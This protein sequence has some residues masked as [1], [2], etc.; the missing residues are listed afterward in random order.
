MSK[1]VSAE[2]EDELSIWVWLPGC[3]TYVKGAGLACIGVQD[4]DAVPCLS[5]I[6]DVSR[7]SQTVN[8]VLN[9]FSISASQGLRS[10]Q[11][12]WEGGSPDSLT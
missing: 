9:G 1:V 10:S 11:D 5:L 2:Q 4:V 7:G 3:D 12:H 8:L 6:D